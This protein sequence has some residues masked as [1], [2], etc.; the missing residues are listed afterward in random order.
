MCLCELLFIH[1]L[2][3]GPQKK[4]FLSTGKIREKREGNSNEIR[5][6]L[7]IYYNLEVKGKLIF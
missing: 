1:I 7:K 2:S 3:L 4:S 5:Y 6:R